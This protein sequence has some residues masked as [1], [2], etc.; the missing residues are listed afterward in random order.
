MERLH[1]GPE[2]GASLHQG[3]SRIKVELKK[4]KKV[5][6]VGAEHV[7]VVPWSWHRAMTDS[8]ASLPFY[9]KGNRGTGPSSHTELV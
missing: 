2:G 4:K 3:H 7:Q 5:E 9:R 1:P 6:G 8:A